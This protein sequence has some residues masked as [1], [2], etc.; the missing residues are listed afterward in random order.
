MNT[1]QLNVNHED[2]IIDEVFQRLLPPLAEK[3]FS[4]LE[5]SLLKYGV[6]DPL[7]LWDGILIDGYNRFE[8]SKKHD[9]PINTV[10]MEFPS[11]DS[12]I[13]WIIKNQMERRNLT[14]AEVRLYRGIHYNT[15]KRMVGN[16]T[17]R[18]QYSEEFLQNEEIPQNRSTVSKLA[19]H[20]N[21]SRSTIERDGKIANTMEVIENI[22]P[23]TKADILSGKTHITNKQ[24]QELSSAPAEEIK[25]IISQIE[26]GTFESRKS[27]V[28]NDAEA[29]ATEDMP[30]WEIE[31]AKMTEEFRQMIKKQSPPND[32]DVIK[33]A[34][35]QYIEML[36][37]L[38]RG[39]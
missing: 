22:S 21:V 4:D 2:V 7:V 25:N 29:N 12:V 19:E 26:D 23:D 20:Y 3:V 8:I 16:I 30:Q 38:Y 1:M 18:N 24:L 32:T 15:E 9:L 11:R 27:P 36:E 39:I 37:G 35:R 28:K 5:E 33:S 34:L 31:F 10:S 6:R 13:I 17:G 14:P